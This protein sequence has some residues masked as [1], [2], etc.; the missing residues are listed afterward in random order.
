MR[1]R[2]SLLWNELSTQDCTRQDLEA[3]AFLGSKIG[4]RAQAGPGFHVGPCRRNYVWVLK[5]REISDD[6]L[7]HAANSL[8]VSHTCQHSR[9][10]GLQQQSSFHKTRHTP[11]SMRFN[12]ETRAPSMTVRPGHSILSLSHLRGNGSAHH[13]EKTNGTLHFIR[14]AVAIGGV[15]SRPTSSSLLNWVEGSFIL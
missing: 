5:S 15:R 7:S 8:Y 12:P 6:N 1:P 3:F 2:Q 14:S 10:V 9:C 4:H 11:C 13:V